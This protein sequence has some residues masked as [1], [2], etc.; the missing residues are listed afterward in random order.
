VIQQT[1]HV[2]GAPS[3]IR[4]AFFLFLSA[5]QNCLAARNNSHFASGFWPLWMAVAV[6]PVH[7]PS[8]GFSPTQDAQSFCPSTNLPDML[9]P[10]GT[11]N[12]QSDQSVRPSFFTMCHRDQIRSDP[13]VRSVE[14]RTT[15]E[16]LPGV[17]WL[18]VFMA[19]TR[20]FWK[21]VFCRCQ[22]TV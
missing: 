20:T 8:G 7:P 10:D 3:E 9:R 14:S 12:R 16:F 22:R 2:C 13:C 1:C 11:S 4:A 17:G 18:P 21:T 5:S 6:R 19:A 15:P